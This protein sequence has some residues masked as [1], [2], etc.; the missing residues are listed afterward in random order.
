[1]S[2]PALV[3]WDSPR[4]GEALL[5]EKTPIHFAVGFLAGASGVNPSW[6][7]ATVI[8][9]EAIVIT[10]E[11]SRAQTIFRK[12]TGESY[13]NQ[14]VDILMGILGAQYGGRFQ[15]NYVARQQIA[16]ANQEMSTQQQSQTSGV[17][18]VR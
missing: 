13:G 11:E 5:D 16:T 7:T 10:L 8:M 12:R 2:A 4:S 9:F 3:S 15:Q 1:M 14:I 6:A 18:G 17:F